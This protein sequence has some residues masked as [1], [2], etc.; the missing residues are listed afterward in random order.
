MA[1]RNGPMLVTLVAVFLLL[2]FYFKLDG[3]F[4]WNIGKAGLGLSFVIFIHELGHFL[5]AKW[6]DVHVQTFSIGFG[7]AIPGC[8]F[9]WGETTYKL[10]AF[11]LGGYVQMVGQVD[12]HEESDGSEEDPRSYKNKSVWQRMAIISAGVVM[13]VLLAIVCFIAVFQGPGKD[14]KSAI[15]NVVASGSPAFDKGLPTGAVITRIGDVENPYFEDLMAVVMAT[16]EGQHLPLTYQVGTEPPVT[17]QIEPRLSKEDTR[18]IIGISPPP[19][20]QFEDKKFLSEFRNP[21]ALRS[22]ASQAQ[23]PFAFSDTIVAMTDPDRPDKVTELPLDPRKPGSKQRDY[24]EYARR[25]QRLAGKDVTIRVLRGP[26]G[27]QQA[28]DIKVPP[29]FHFAFPARMQMGQITAI[30]QGST[31][32]RPASRPAIRVARS[33][34]TSS[35]GRDPGARR[36][37]DDL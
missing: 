21:V 30:R 5:V 24:F 16:Q 33:T 7:P 4:W 3:G 10:A 2:H 28:V 31:A 9:K 35:R 17:I 6:C 34:A 27:Q 18:P 14:R 19:R 32:A 8:S 15:V 22:A 26:E 29:A 13:N 12:M 1:A 25:M 37:G 20:L 11:P 23:P 36:N